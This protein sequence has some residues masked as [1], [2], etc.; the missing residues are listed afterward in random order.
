MVT[1]EAVPVEAVPVEGRAVPVWL[2]GRASHF[3][4]SVLA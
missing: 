2:T 4:F 3:V 1:G